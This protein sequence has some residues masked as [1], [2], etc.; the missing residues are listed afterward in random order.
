MKLKYKILL[1]FALSIGMLVSI[2]AYTLSFLRRTNVRINEITG[3]Q[4]ATQKLIQSSNLVVMQI[5]SDIW[6]AML[7]GVDVRAERTENVKA[8]ARSFYENMR[9]LEEYLPE[10][11]GD[12]SAMKSGQV[13]LFLQKMRLAYEIA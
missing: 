7:F 10:K 11:R 6:D 9:E 1:G 8:Q 3:K 4:F 12:L 13:R 5:H 2:E